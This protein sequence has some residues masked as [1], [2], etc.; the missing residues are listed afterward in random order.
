MRLCGECR[1]DYPRAGQFAEKPGYACFPLVAEGKSIKNPELSFAAMSAPADLPGEPE[2]RIIRRN[3]ARVRLGVPAKIQLLSGLTSCRLDNLSQRG[4][5]IM[6]AEVAPAVGARGLLIVCG[7]EAF[8]EVIWF[9][10]M[11]CGL[12]FD[13]RLPLEQV[14]AVRHFSDQWTGNEAP[15]RRPMVRSSLQRSRNT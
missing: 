4:A 14:V 3:D 12:R 9:R 5:R 2:S 11:A 13:Q 15:G 8:G 10:G 1:R 7:I 6:L